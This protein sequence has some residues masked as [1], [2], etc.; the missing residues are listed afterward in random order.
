ML[1]DFIVK[2]LV[3]IING[4]LNSS[5]HGIQKFSQFVLLIFWKGKKTLVMNF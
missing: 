2:N 4:S 1:C 3:V 5:S